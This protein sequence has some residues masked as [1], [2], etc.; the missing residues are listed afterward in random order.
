MV[1]PADMER[2]RRHLTLLGFVPTSSSLSIFLLD[3]Y[4]VSLSF[5]RFQIY[6]N[7]GDHYKKLNETN[8]SSRLNKVLGEILYANRR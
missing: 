1:T 2:A 7:Q 5:Y 8:C 6:S 3:D 4:K